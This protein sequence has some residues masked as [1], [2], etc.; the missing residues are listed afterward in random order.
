MKSDSKIKRFLS[1]DITL[2]VISLILAFAIWFVINANA[3]TERNTTIS[4]IPI[5]IELPEELVEDGY[6]VFTTTEL[7]ASVEVSGNR[8]TV[9]SLNANDIKIEALQRNPIIAPGPYTLDLS[10][11]KQGVKSNYNF[12]SGVTPS[13]IQV[14]VDKRKEVEL[15]ITNSVVCNVEKEGYYKNSWLSSNTV[16]I[17][18]PEAEVSAIDKVTVQGTLEGVVGE[19]VNDKFD[20]VFLDKD[21]KELNLTYSKTSLNE[22]EVYLKPL[23]TLEVKLEI[24]TKNAP[25]S[26]PKIKITPSKVKIAAEQEVLDRYYKDKKVV[27]DTLDFSTLTNKKTVVERDIRLENGCKLLSDSSTAKVSINLSGYD[28]KKLVIN[29]FASENIDLKT[30]SVEFH[31]TSLEITVFGP[32]DV[33]D[34]ITSADVICKVD[35][36]GVSGDYYNSNDSFDLPFTFKL[37]NKYKDCWVYGEYIADVIV[38]KK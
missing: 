21:G 27:L 37:T 29:S 4:N 33:V 18:G 13:Q 24:D 1:K 3:E 34:D 7:T 38:T 23:P 30:Y 32:S 17:S 35:F 6:E 2:F 36:D 9:G 15:N 10:A 14:F 12:V 11:S 31:N 19:T 5:T 25:A 16:T 20:L 22:V 26:H 8:L 28:E